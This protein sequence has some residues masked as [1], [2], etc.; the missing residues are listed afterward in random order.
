MLTPHQREIFDNI[1]KA[2]QTKRHVTLTGF[3][4]TGKTFVINELMKHFSATD[5]NCAVCAPTHKALQV[6]AEKLN[7]HYDCFTIASLLGLHP[8]TDILNF[9]PE[10]PIFK[11]GKFSKHHVYDMVIIDEAS[12]I[13]KALFRKLC[14]TDLKILFVGDPAQLPPVNEEESLAFTCISPIFKLHEIIRTNKPDI[15]DLC[16]VLRTNNFHEVYNWKSSENITVVKQRLYDYSSSKIL[17]YRNVTVNKWNTSAK[18][19]L[20]PSPKRIDIGDKVMFYT[21]I[22]HGEQTLIANS[23]ELIVT[24]RK[25]RSDA[26]DFIAFDKVIKNLD[27]HICN[28]PGYF[29]FLKRYKKHVD[30]KDWDELYNLRKKCLTD[31]DLN[32]ETVDRTTDKTIFKS[33]DLSYALTVHKSQGSTFDSVAVDLNDIAGNTDD[34]RALL[35]TAVSRAANK[36]ILI[37]G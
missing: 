15:I 35:Y 16:S 6:I 11:S 32:L 24:E 27:F 30:N 25:Y 1:L 21:P 28:P 9:D 18:K 13:N 2:F 10:K 4:G 23:E 26:M 37:N 14:N 3:A 12:M 33:F 34:L 5:V 31:I 19:Q 22:R 36:I 20:N 7:T 17:S 8:D 29:E